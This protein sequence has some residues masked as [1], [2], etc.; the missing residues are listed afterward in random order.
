MYKGTNNRHSE[1]IEFAASAREFKDQVQAAITAVLEPLRREGE[2]LP[3][4]EELLEL[5]ARLLEQS[6]GEL[7][8]TDQLYT[9][10]LVGAAALRG[11]RDALVAQLEIRI[12]DVRYLLDRSVGTA[13]AKATLRERRTTKIKPGLLVGAARDL[14]K[15]LRDPQLALE[16]LT[17]KDMFADVERMAAKIEEEANQLEEVLLRLA[18]QKKASE[19][20]LGAKVAGIDA[21]VE[22]NRRC[23][24]LLFGLYRLAGLDFHAERLRPKA[25]RRKAKE[26]EKAEASPPSVALM[27]IN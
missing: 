15:T 18:P 4:L 24:D 12:R 3:Q 5:I 27:R 22:K 9:S 11:D 23:A 25:R 21:A 20:H 10:K 8:A 2:S 17:D 14:V 16:T 26:P 13:V 1:A 19:R 6:G 7:L